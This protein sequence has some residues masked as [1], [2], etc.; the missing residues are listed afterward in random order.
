MRLQ[1]YIDLFYTNPASDLQ[2]LINERLE[3]LCSS[4]TG[5][6]VLAIQA[7]FRLQKLLEMNPEERER[8]YKTAIEKY[9]IEKYKS[10]ISTITDEYHRTQ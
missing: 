7:Q 8:V 6:G 3:Y 1:K 4:A 5:S 2:F 9:K 10:E